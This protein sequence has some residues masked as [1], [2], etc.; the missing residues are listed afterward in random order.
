MQRRPLAL[1][2]GLELRASLLGVSAGLLATVTTLAQFNQWTKD[3]GI[4]E[5]FGSP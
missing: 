2:A 1:V 5:D 3:G 4:V